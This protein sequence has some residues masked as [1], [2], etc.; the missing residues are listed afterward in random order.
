MNNL[1]KAVL[2][3]ALF[4][5]VLCAQSATRPVSLS[6]TASTSSGVLGYNAFRAQGSGAPAQLNTSLIAGTSYTDTTAVIGNTYSYTVVAVAA[7]CTNTT[8]V[9]VACGS[10]PA[11]A[12][13]ATTVPQ[14][15]VVSISVTLTVP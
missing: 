13:V 14:Q 2:V 6:W 3:I 1:Q 15:P 7:P 8:P 10:S 9:T 5:L 4:G 11:S 12:A